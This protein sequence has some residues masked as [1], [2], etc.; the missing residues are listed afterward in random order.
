MPNMTMSL[1]HSGGTARRGV[2]L[3]LAA[4]AAVASILV[5]R[6][7]PVASDA[8]SVPAGSSLVTQGIL[9]ASGLPMP[10]SVPAAPAAPSQVRGT[11]P[12]RRPRIEVALTGVVFSDDPAISRALL[13]FAD[14]RLSVEAVGASLAEDVWLLG[15]DRTSVTLLEGDRERMILLEGNGARNADRRTRTTALAAPTRAVGYEGHGAS[16]TQALMRS[17]RQGTVEVRGP[18]G[19]ETV[20]PLAIDR[21]RDPSRLSGAPANLRSD[22]RHR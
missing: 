20:A 5:L 2:L 7:D 16:E 22:G 19:P 11:H 21:R 18:S 17:L 6:T 12:V 13:R 15:I 14:G 10:P 9:S 1:S 4:A 8:G 3:L